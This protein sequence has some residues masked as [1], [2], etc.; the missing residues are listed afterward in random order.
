MAKIRKKLPEMDVEEW[1]EFWGQCQAALTI[2][3]FSNEL[4]ADPDVYQAQWIAH[5]MVRHG[6][7]PELSEDEWR[8]FGS[9][10]S[11]LFPI[12]K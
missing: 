4:T 8:K 1:D 10:C 12:T 5:E 9:L 7:A 2:I 11:L 6:K 3:W